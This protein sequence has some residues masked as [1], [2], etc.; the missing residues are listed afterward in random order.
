MPDFKHEPQL[1]MV[2]GRAILAINLVSGKHTG[3]MKMADGS[4]LKGTDKK[5]GILTYDHIRTNEENKTTEEWEYMDHHSMLGQL[6]LAPKEQGPTRPAIEKGW[7]G[8]P[9][10]LVAKDDA[11][12]KA[13]LELLGKS[14]EA[15]NAH[16]PADVSALWA[17][18]IVVSDQAEATDTKGKAENEKGLKALFAAF[19]DA[20]ISETHHFA[21][22]DYVV[23]E[24]RLTG[25]HKGPLGPMKP[26][27]KPIDLAYAEVF[28]L[29]GGKVVELW[30]F[31][32]GMAMMAQ[33]TAKPAPKGEAPKGDAPKGDAPKTDA[34]KAD[35]P[36]TDAPK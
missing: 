35:A 34:P 9:I 15:F 3:P 29:K 10:I 30:R 24:G 1:V 31:R 17:D 23:V 21:S 12:E 11:A 26:T 6:G 18:D 33:L 4:E 8:A 22:G 36:K 16:K 28:K 2:S 25:T 19:P 27:N 13:N 32:D 20:K 7:P 14:T 5:F